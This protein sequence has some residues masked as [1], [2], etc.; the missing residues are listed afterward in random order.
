VATHGERILEQFSKK[1]DLYA[2]APELTD[3]DTL[4][5]LIQLSGATQNDTLL[6]VACGA[7][8]LVC[9][10]AERV[11]HATGIDLVPA[12]IDRARTLA[13]EKNIANVGWQV[14]DVL[15]LP[16]PDE[17]FSLVTSRYAFHH[18]ENPGKMLNEMKRVCSRAGRIL[19]ADMAA[20][21]DQTKANALNRMEKLRDPSHV[22]SMSAAELR[23]LFCDTALIP[24]RPSFYQI[25]FDLE[26]LL[27]GSHP[28]PGDEAK[29]RAMLNQTLCEE[30]MGLNVRR[31]SGGIRLSYTIAVLVA[32]KS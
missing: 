21:E 1:A 32:R 8:V 27:Q 10:F 17:S 24:T 29:L 20:P 25:H 28:L 30:T 5:F 3:E 4:R 26:S 6:D 19:V 2:T 12:M 16:F 13:A 31:E 9:S 14:G 22:R 23:K 15:A 18:V 7:G 11:K